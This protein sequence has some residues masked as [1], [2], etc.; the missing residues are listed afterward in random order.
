MPDDPTYV[1]TC[2][3]CDGKGFNGPEQSPAVFANLVA[4]DLEPCL[5]CGGH[6][7]M[8]GRGQ[9]RVRIVPWGQSPNR[10]VAFLRA[11]GKAAE[12]LI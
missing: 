6:D 2:P 4:R 3:V 11:A 10:F 1:V 7:R 5:T 8:T 12:T 9:V